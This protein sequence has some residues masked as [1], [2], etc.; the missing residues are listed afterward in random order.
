MSNA[1]ESMLAVGTYEYPFSWALPE[2]IPASF[3]GPYGWIR[4]RLE[5]IV[6]H[7]FWDHRCE[8]EAEFYVT[9]HYDLNNLD[10]I[11]R[12][13]QVENKGINVYNCYGANYLELTF[14]LEK[15]AYVPG[16]M[17]RFGATVEFVN[18]GGH[19]PIP[20]VRVALVHVRIHKLFEGCDF[21]IF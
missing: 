10:K 12:E 2:N 5:V 17:V 20:G 6:R 11:Y 4:Y 3:E 21:K 1:E 15:K 18:R 9:G 8:A 19:P 7:S 16:E 14:E 13:V